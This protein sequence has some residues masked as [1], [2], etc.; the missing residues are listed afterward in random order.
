MEKKLSSSLSGGMTNVIWFS[1]YILGNCYKAFKSYPFVWQKRLFVL[2]ALGAP[3]RVSM[4]R[5]P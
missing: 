1:D 4:L 5:A 2:G 3:A